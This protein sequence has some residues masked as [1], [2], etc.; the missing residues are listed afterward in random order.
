MPVNA[1]AL[2]QKIEIQT[3]RPGQYPD[4]S[5]NH[6][7]TTTYTRS[8]S[9][10]ATSGRRNQQ[11]YDQMPS[12]QTQTVV[13]RRDSKTRQITTANRF[14]WKERILQIV[15]AMEMDLGTDEERMEF[16]VAY[17]QEGA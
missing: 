17:R 9:I 4:G 5:P 1:G 16:Q 13:M 6:N 11:S 8:A 12:D 2:N 14:K 15:S 10:N 7:W 3:N